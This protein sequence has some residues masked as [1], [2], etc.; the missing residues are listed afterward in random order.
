MYI[1]KS[2]VLR[3][4]HCAWCHHRYCHLT[5]FVVG[6]SSLSVTCHICR[7]N[8]YLEVYSKLRKGDLRD[9]KVLKFLVLAEI[10]RECDHV[11]VV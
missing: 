8:Y 3:R 10:Q 4:V 9:D 2:Q 6:Y 5:D 7:L 1:K 11:D